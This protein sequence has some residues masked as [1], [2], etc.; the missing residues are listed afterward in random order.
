MGKT[1]STSG[2]EMTCL[3]SF[4]IAPRKACVFFQAEGG[5][6]YIGVTGVQTCALPIYRPVS[7]REVLQRLK[8]AGL[9][10]LPGGGGEI[11]VDR[12]RKQLTKNKALTDEWLEVMRVWHQLGGR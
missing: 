8:A 10:S 1:G 3:R 7:R 2:T 12:V 9:G 5:I 11:L 4:A 6:R